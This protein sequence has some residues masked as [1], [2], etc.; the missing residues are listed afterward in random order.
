MSFMSEPPPFIPGMSFMSEPP[1]FIPG[2]SFM[3]EPPPFIPGMSL[4][5]PSFIGIAGDCAFS[6]LTCSSEDFLGAALGLADA[7]S[8]G[9][10]PDMS[11]PSMPAM[12]SMRF[13]PPPWAIERPEKH[14]EIDPSTTATALRAH[15]SCF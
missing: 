11:I 10:E 2:M 14:K 5:G 8:P 4:V 3:A 12:S 15:L 13:A 6:M 7:R 1:P 9:L